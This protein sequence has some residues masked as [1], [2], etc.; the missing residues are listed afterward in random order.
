M[1]SKAIAK[2][3]HQSPFKIRKTLDS[4]RGM[5][6]NDALNYLHFSSEKA[7][8]EAEASRKKTAQSAKEKPLKT[9]LSFFIRL[10]KLTHITSDE[11]NEENRYN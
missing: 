1:E 9:S 6:V 7:A 11:S 8:T 10:Q 3:I 2:Y 4:I 5:S